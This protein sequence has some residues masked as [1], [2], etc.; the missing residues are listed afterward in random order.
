MA[1]E[2]QPQRPQIRFQRRGAR[3]L[4][5]KR[6]SARP[7]ARL[8]ERLARWPSDKQLNVAGAD[9]RQVKQPSSS[10]D[11]VMNIPWCRKGPSG[12]V[13]AQRSSSVVVDLNAEP[14]VESG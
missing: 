9:L 14:V 2:E 8:R 1:E 5:P 6:L 10:A 12:A 4:E 3:I 13:H 11:V 7:V